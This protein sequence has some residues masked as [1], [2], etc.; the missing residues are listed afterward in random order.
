MSILGLFQVYKQSLVEL[1][2]PNNIMNNI[3]LSVGR[4]KLLLLPL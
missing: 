4:Y 1:E 3:C 2:L